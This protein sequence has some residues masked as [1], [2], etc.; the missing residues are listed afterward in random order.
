[1]ASAWLGGPI[2]LVGLMGA[3]KTT[4]GKLAAAE[5]A[6]PFY[7]IDEEI[8]L[9]CGADIPWIF[10]VEGEQGFR[11]REA[12]VLED[13]VKQGRGVISTGGGI[14]IGEQN[15][16]VL[17]ASGHVVYLC[18]TAEQL[19][20][21]IG[22]DKRRPL[23]QTEDPLARLKSLLLAREGFYRE[24]ADQVFISDNSAP[25][26]AAKKLVAAILSSVE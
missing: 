19:Y 21:R 13:I 9:R 26:E 22:R 14:V 25:K 23:L 16:A 12:H 18:S 5:L 24:V 2:F 6:I 8:Q 20:A 7:D 3:G 10:D 15:R 17:K 11:E 1:M 4:L